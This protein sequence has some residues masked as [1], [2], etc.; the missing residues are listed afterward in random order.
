MFIPVPF[1][2]VNSPSDLHPG[3]YRTTCAHY[4]RASSDLKVWLFKY[5]APESDEPLAVDLLLMD[6]E[7]ALRARDFIWMP[8]RS[9]RD[10]DGGR[11]NR[12]EALLPAELLGL[13][14]RR[15]VALEDVEVGADE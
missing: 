9:W 13:Q 10:S 5:T 8:D 6:G 14:E 1:R 12:L 11:A 4:A 3:R 7:G 15:C 2:S